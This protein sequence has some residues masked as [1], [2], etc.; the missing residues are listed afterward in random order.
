L[1]EAEESLI[2]GRISRGKNDQITPQRNEERIT[3]K[4][5]SNV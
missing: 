2:E 4:G 1:D 5:S 3:E